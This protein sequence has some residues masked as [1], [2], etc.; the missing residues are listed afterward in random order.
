MLS[1]GGV[2]KHTSIDAIRNAPS[3]SDQLQLSDFHH[4]FRAILDWNGDL[5]YIIRFTAASRV[6]RRLRDRA[7]ADDCHLD[8]FQV[9]AWK[10]RAGHWRKR[11]R[12]GIGL[13]PEDP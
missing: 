3:V 7:T 13:I 4:I 1:P 12:D 9:D 8:T 10:S 11:A 5:G 2:S 6:D